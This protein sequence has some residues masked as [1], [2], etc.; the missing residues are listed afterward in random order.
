MTVIAKDVT[1]RIL[2]VAIGPGAAAQG[3]AWSGAGLDVATVADAG[4]GPRT[5]WWSGG[6]IAARPAPPAPPSLTAGVA[7]TWAGL[8]TGA[9]VIVVD[10]STGVEAGSGVVDGDLVLTLPAG[11]WRLEVSAAFPSQA[12]TFVVEV[13]E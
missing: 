9:T 7:A 4:I 5:H 1:G 12:A 11:A 2:R 3:V 6:A 8:P 13:V 10:P